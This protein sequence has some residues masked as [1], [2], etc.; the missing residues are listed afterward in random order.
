MCEEG[1]SSGVESMT[2]ARSRSTR[3]WPSPYTQH[4]PRANHWTSRPTVEGRDS[5]GSGLRGLKSYLAPESTRVLR[6]CMQSTGFN[7]WYFKWSHK[8]H[9][10]L[11]LSSEPKW[12]PENRTR[13]NLR[14][15]LQNKLA[16]DFHIAA[17]TKQ[18]CKSEGKG[19][20]RIR[21]GEINQMFRSEPRKLRHLEE[22][23]GVWRTGEAV[24]Q[25]V[26]HWG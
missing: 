10:G 24:L 9:Q 25:T 26:M 4:P 1:G 23:G 14:P 5:Q 2:L 15:L 20:K 19:Y 7:P 11:A 16:R 22:K 13:S 3:A 17:L 8:H 6:P 12:F 21:K 18:I